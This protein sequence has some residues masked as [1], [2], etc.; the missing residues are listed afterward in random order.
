MVNPAVYIPER[1][2]V[3]WVTLDPQARREQAGHRPAVVLS[4]A[5]Y[6]GKVGLAIM[7]PITSQT[8]DYPFEVLVPPGLDVSGV[9]LADQIK[10]LDWRERKAKLIC[11]LPAATLAEV[12]R[13]LST[14]LLL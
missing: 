4:T 12:L 5:S 9:I 6:N 13:K 7:C 8:K 11:V 2:D 3:V 10:N 14:L 1:G